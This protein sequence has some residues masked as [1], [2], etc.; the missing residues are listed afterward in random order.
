MPKY[1]YDT[2]AQVFLDNHKMNLRKFKD[3]K[4]RF[5]ILLLNVDTTVTQVY[6]L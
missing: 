3:Y 2:L 1:H 6:Q 4:K 5:Y